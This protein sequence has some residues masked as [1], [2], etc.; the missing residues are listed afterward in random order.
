MH[1]VFLRIPC[2]RRLCIL[3]GI[4]PVEPKNKKKA[5]GANKTYYRT[6]DVQFL[7]HEPV[8]DKFR[9]FK[10]FV[11]RLRKAVGRDDTE[12]ATKLSTN[13]P[14]LP[15]DHIVRERLVCYVS[16]VLPALPAHNIPA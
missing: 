4:F 14:I 10:V 1:A 15:L 2:C 3:K 9:Q 12:F 8:L 7:A 6:K 5:G 16:V 11:K 13:E